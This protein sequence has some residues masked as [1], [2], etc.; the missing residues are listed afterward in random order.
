MGGGIEVELRNPGEKENKESREQQ[1]THW[2][3]V[4][5]RVVLSVVE[6]TARRVGI[7]RL[8]MHCLPAG[9]SSESR[10]AGCVRGVEALGDPIRKSP[11]WANTEDVRLRLSR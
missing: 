4:N 10:L 2:T 6:E 8:C 3:A 5:N 7:M 11:A 1:F 9:V